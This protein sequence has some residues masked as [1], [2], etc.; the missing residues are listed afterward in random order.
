[1]RGEI[2]LRTIK[3]DKIGFKKFISPRNSLKSFESVIITYIAV[4]II[5]ILAG[6]VLSRFNFGA[7]ISLDHLSSPLSFIKWFLSG[8]SGPGSYYMPIIVQLI[9]FFPLV[10]LLV[11]KLKS[12]GLLCSLALNATYEIIV[13]YCDM[14]PQIYRILIFRYTFLIAL[15]IYLA[16]TK[17]TKRDNITAL[18]FLIAGASLI[19]VN[20]YIRPFP[21][22][23]DWKSTSMLCVPFA[24]GIIYFLKKFF[25]DMPYNK[26]FIIGKASF[27]IYLTQMVFFGF[28]GGRIL[29]IIFDFTPNVTNKILQSIVA[30]LVCVSVGVL[31]F[32]LETKI[33]QLFTKKSKSIPKEM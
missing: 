23:Q 14:N 7:D 26:L 4:V 19:F 18:I 1:M 27:H 25:E 21:L 22:F 8:A 13:Y 11:G 10:W 17:N 5:E 29:K 20:T 28:G 32:I 24:Y 3:I 30:I 9:L 16:I 15:G 6:L 33:K 12:L 31:F 2:Y